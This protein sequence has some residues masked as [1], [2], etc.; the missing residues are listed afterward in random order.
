MQSFKLQSRVQYMLQL[1]SLRAIAVLGVLI[2]HFYPESESLGLGYYGVRLFFVLSG[3]LITAILL[4]ARNRIEQT[5]QRVS[6]AICQ[7]YVRRTLR[8]VPVYYLALV[9]ALLLGNTDIFSGAW[10]YASYT[11]N[12]FF[13]HL[14]FYPSTTAHLWSLSVEAQFYLIWPFVILLVAK[15]RIHW[16]IVLTILAGPLYRLLGIVGSHDG[17]EFYTFT[18]SSIDSLG[19]GALLAW[20]LHEEREAHLLKRAGLGLFLL[21]PI[22]TPILMEEAYFYVLDNTLL[23]IAYVWLITGAAKGF[24]GPVGGILN[25]KP[26][27]YIGQI[28]YGVYLYHLFIPWGLY[29]VLGLTQLENPV[30]NAII[31]ITTTILVASLSWHL[32]EKPINGL[33]KHFPYPTVIPKAQQGLDPAPK[34]E[35]WGFQQNYRITQ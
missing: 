32:F 19:W 13:I 28:S 9:I 26:L 27:I 20:L 31:L 7:F 16:A 3:F 21:F 25:W 8:I 10:W 18:L 35:R 29:E 12:L 4:D 24:S 1:D 11:T 6:S 5:G 15:Q 17:I 33:K 34:V 30:V 23:S 22:V 2:H 14:G